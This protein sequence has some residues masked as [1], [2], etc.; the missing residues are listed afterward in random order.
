MVCVAFVLLVRLGFGWIKVPR[1]TWWVEPQVYPMIVPCRLIWEDGTFVFRPGFLQPAIDP[2]LPAYWL[3]IGIAR[4][5]LGPADRAA[6]VRVREVYGLGVNIH[7]CTKARPPRLLA[8]RG[9]HALPPGARGQ[10]TEAG[11]VGR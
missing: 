5:P 2:D 11:G 3:H 8:A 4:F 7:V 6:E 9:H 1:Q 10:G